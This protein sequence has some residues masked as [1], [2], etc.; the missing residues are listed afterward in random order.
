MGDGEPSD[1]VRAQYRTRRR[2]QGAI[3]GLSVIGLLAM[4]VLL[5]QGEARSP[6]FF[7]A[8]LCVAALAGLALRN[9]R[10]P[11]CGR[12]LGRRPRLAACP[13]C[14]AALE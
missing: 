10:C 14:G 9:W 5:F 7:G 3:A 1:R 8:A 11:A 12:Y 4:L 13:G 6:W 2:R